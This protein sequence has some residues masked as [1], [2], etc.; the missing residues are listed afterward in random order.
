VRGGAREYVRRMADGLEDI[1][2]D[3]P[4]LRVTRGN[5]CRVHTLDGVEPFDE[6]VLACHSDQALSILGA[7]ATPAE[8][9]ILGAI[10]WQRNLALLH[11]DRSLLPRRSRVWSAWNYM[12]GEA[13]AGSRP[14]SVSY[15]INRLQPLPFATPVIVS[16][17][18]FRE[19]DPDQ[20]LRVMHY[21]HPVLDQAALSAQARLDEIQGT[22]GVW[23]A[24]AWTGYGFHEDGLASALSVVEAL[25]ARV[26]WRRTEAAA[27]V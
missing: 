26:P 27:C 15:L 13:D 5:G 2:L 19:V 14:V 7:D 22:G 12:S 1:R 6:V 20:L 21:A 3:T 18:P 8:R 24:G 4:V 25:G 10:R 17:N 11:T 23:F 9:G 16:L